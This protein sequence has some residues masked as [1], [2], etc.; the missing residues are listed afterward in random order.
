MMSSSGA[1][2]LTGSK[3]TC[4]GAKSAFPAVTKHVLVAGIRVTGASQCI[5][6]ALALYFAAAEPP[7]HSASLDDYPCIA[8]F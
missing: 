2:D 3:N 5:Q 1:V 4:F 8:T 6:A 7:M